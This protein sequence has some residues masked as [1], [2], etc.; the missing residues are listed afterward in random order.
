MNPYRFPLDFAPAFPFA[1]AGGLAG[2]LPFGGTFFFERAPASS[3]S[4]PFVFF[5]SCAFLSAA[6]GV[7]KKRPRM[8]EPT[9]TSQLSFPIRPNPRLR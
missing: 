6:S 1:F 7:K 4:S 2:A 8:G 5:A 3:D 9:H